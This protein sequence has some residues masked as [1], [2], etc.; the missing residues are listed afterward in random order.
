MDGY[1]RTIPLEFCPT[2]GGALFYL[3]DSSDDFDPM[4]QLRFCNEFRQ[5]L[6]FEQKERIARKLL[7]LAVDLINEEGGLQ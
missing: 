1:I 4:L 6:T 2:I 7:L 5:K 3:G